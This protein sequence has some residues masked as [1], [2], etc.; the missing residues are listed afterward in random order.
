MGTHSTDKN[1]KANVNCDEGR[2]LGCETFCCRLLV[3]LDPNERSLDD[4]GG[5]PPKGY[6][7]KEPD[8]NC[9][10]FDKEKMLCKIWEKRPRV[11]RE[12]ECNSDFLLQVAIRNGF[13][14]LGKLVKEAASAYIPKETYVKVPLNTSCA[15][16]CTKDQK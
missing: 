1:T 6:V 16:S 14:S 3:R 9:I 15:D 8:G 5:L 4:N 7:D 2:R 13:T 12:Y 11:C 10:H